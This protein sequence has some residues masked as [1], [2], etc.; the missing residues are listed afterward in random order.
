VGAVEGQQLVANNK[1]QRRDFEGCKWQTK[2]LE[3]M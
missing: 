1:V 2:P 3:N